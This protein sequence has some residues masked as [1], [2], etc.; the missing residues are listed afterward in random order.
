MTDDLFSNAPS[1]RPTWGSEKGKGLHHP[2]SKC[3]HEVAPFGR[4]VSLRKGKLGEWFCTK[5]LP[6]DFYIRQER[7]IKGPS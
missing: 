6:D 7:L 5:C 1:V 3:G 4:N 2:C